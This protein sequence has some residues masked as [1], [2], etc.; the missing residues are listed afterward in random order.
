MGGVVQLRF[1][2]DTDS[3]R[4]TQRTQVSTMSIRSTAAL[5]AALL[6]SP[7]AQA[8]ELTYDFTGR[9][10]VGGTGH[11]YTGVFTYNDDVPASTVYQTGQGAVQQGFQSSYFGAVHFLGITLDNG[12]TVSAS[13]GTLQVNNIQQAE[14]GAQVP[15]GLSLQAWT[16]GGHGT[17]N[18]L[19]VF[20]LYLAFLPVT[21]A[22]SWDALDAHFGGNA[23][24]LLSDHPS[25]LPAD[26]DPRLTGT[27]LPPLLTDTFVHGLFLG[28]NHGLTNTVNEVDSFMLRVAAPV[29]EPGSLALMLAGGLAVAA[30][31]RRRAVPRR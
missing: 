6:L 9:T 27:D 21:P 3:A 14:I 17:I 5:L 1:T 16:G 23:E 12:E 7:L 11:A 28:T 10:W 2:A 31:L 22:F 15:A 19:P 26:I 29:P 24:Q 8:T 25:L 30:A 13:V 4:L 18:G 20:N